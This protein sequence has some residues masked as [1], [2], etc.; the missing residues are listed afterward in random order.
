MPELVETLIEDARWKE[1]G[2][3][4]LAEVAARNTLIHLTLNPDDFAISLIGCDDARI[5][6]LN[7]DFREK[8]TATNV[9]SWPSQERGADVPGTRPEPPKPGP[10]PPEELGDIAIAYETC[11]AEAQAADTPISAHVTHLIVHATLHLLGYDH[12]SDAD[13]DLMEGLEVEILASMGQA[14]PYM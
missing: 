14:D 13:A 8:P 5:M 7:T 11:L 3:A 1:L 2:L 6:T 12:I 4:T 10:M 9:L